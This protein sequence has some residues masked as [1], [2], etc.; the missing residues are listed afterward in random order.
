MRFLADMG[1]SSR[2]VTWLRQQGHNTGTP[3]VIQR[4]K[5]VL[6]ASSELLAAG[7]VV[8]IEETR[9]RIRHSRRSWTFFRHLRAWAGRAR[10]AR[11]LLNSVEYASFGYCGSSANGRSSR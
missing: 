1:V 4:L 2:V 11:N 10:E 3:H 7:S 8:V 5:A 6:A 9:H